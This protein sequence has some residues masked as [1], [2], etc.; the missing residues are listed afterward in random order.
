MMSVTHTV[1]YPMGTGV[2]R[3]RM[4]ADLSTV[5]DALLNVH[6]SISLVINELNA[7]ILVL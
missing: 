4:E 3:T 5:F 2:M 6:L 7:Q 1:S